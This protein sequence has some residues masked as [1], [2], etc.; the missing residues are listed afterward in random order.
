MTD[1]P[2][3]TPWGAP[4]SAPRV[5]AP[6]VISYTT[7][8]HGGIWLDPERNAMVPLAWRNASHGGGALDG[9]YEE[10]C[11]WCLVALVY[12][13]GFTSDMRAQALQTFISCFERK[14][15]GRT[16]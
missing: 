7:A 16:V 6:G 10:D 9:W 5:L 8:S 11:D 14:L 13:D 1:R 12:P 15:V 2:V 3:Y 4:D